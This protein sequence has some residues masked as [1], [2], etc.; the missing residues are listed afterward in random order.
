MSTAP[1]SHAVRVDLQPKAEPPAFELID[2]S[3]AASVRLGVRSFHDAPSENVR[4]LH[5]KRHPAMVGYGKRT[6]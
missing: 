5:E 4:C 1:L 3:G 2:C 6:H